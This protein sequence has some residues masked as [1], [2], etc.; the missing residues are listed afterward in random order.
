MVSRT[1]CR[2]RNGESSSG[3]SGQAQSIASS[4]RIKLVLT[5]EVSGHS[6]ICVQDSRDTSLAGCMHSPSVAL[7]VVIQISC[8]ALA[9]SKHLA[10]Q[11]IILLLHY[12]Q[13]IHARSESSSS[14][15]R[16]SDSQQPAQSASK[17]ARRPSPSNPK[18]AYLILYNFVSALLWSVVLGRV[19]LIGALRGWHNV[20]LG[21]SEFTKWTQTLAGLEV[22]HAATGNQ[23]ITMQTPHSAKHRLSTS[24]SSPF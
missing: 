18:T 19:V 7:S 13:H 8:L 24:S 11:L 9:G 1:R 21:T 23:I 3:Y 22:L 17:S 2:Y 14:M 15:D 20:F 5:S 12:H 10:F 4:V 6:R 16:P